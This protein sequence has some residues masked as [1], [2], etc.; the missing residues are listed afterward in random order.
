MNF[1]YLMSGPTTEIKKAMAMA[2]IEEFPCLK[3]TRGNGHLRTYS[4]F[5]LSHS[6]N[7]YFM[8]VKML[9]MFC[10]TFKEAFYTPGQNGP[11]TG[12][13]EE[14]LRNIRKRMRKLSGPQRREEGRSQSMVIPGEL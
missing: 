1:L 12:F 8:P 13:I 9:C 10:D 14:R 2:L 6:F 3:D 7:P 11:A 4:I 5:F